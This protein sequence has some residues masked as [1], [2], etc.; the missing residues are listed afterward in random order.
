MKAIA[1]QG[2]LAGTKLGS[3]QYA[4]LFRVADSKRRGLVSW[5]DFTVFET[6][7]KRPDADYWIAFQYFDVYVLAYLPPFTIITP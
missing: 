4:L 5:E 3:A 1:P 2:D 7:L 6:L